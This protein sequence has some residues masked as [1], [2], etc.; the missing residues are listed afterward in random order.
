M[1]KHID[2]AQLLTICNQFISL[3]LKRDEFFP[4]EFAELYYELQPRP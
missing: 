1:R 2:I 4:Y 3:S